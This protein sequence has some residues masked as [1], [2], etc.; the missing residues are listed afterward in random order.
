MKLSL[1][2][3]IITLILLVLFVAIGIIVTGYYVAP[4]VEILNIEPN[5]EIIKTGD[6]VYIAA[7]KVYAKGDIVLV[8]A[9]DPEKEKV[10]VCQAY[11]HATRKIVAL[12]GESVRVDKDVLMEAFRA[13]AAL[14]ENERQNMGIITSTT[15]T[16]PIS[17]TILYGVSMPMS[18]KDLLSMR[19]GIIPAG[20]I[21]GVLEG[22]PSRGWSAK[23][24]YFVKRT[25]YL[26]TFVSSK[27]SL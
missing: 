8:N 27:I 17:N 20:M 26:P 13:R 10:G 9:C 2:G 16:D 6:L 19:Q 24:E 11:A 5:E 1:K 25:K 7:K 3:A 18:N 15:L 22:I 14:T 21:Y 12:P 4:I 23:W